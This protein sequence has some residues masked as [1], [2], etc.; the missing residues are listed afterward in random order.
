MICI[1]LTA[2]IMRAFVYVIVV[3]FDELTHS[4]LS[5]SIMT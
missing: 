4:S 2:A 1:V 3:L 5:L